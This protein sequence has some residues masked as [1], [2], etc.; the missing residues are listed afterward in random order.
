MKCPSLSNKGCSFLR[1]CNNS[2]KLSLKYLKRQSTRYFYKPRTAKY[3]SSLR[4]ETACDPLHSVRKI[5]DSNRNG[6][7]TRGRM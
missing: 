7:E 6:W 4:F 2:F 1:R 3:T 5:M